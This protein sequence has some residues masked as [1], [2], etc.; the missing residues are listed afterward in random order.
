LTATDIFDSNGM[1]PPVLSERF[2]SIQQ[3]TRFVG[4]A[5]T[6]LGASAA[7]HGAGDL[8]KLA[9]IDGMGQGVVRVRGGRTMGRCKV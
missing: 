7:F 4:P 6:I 8:E 3:G 5:F 2:F 9:A 1:L